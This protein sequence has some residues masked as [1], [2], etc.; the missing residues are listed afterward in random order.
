MDHQR[1]SNTIGLLGLYLETNRI[2]RPDADDYMKSLEESIVPE[3][4]ERFDGEVLEYKPYFDWER[5]LIKE[6]KGK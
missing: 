3:L 4:K 1:L 6:V 2:S 5:E